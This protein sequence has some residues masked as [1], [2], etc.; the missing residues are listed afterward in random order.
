MFFRVRF[1]YVMSLLLIVGLCSIAQTRGGGPMETISIRVNEGTNL[2]LDLSPDGRNIA[3]DL[4]GQLWLVP[5]GGGN[6]R[7]I[8]DAVRD[9]AEDN[10][11]SFS[12]DGK[13]IVF[14]GERN[15]RTGLFLLDVATGNV[16]QLTQISD[17]ES[18]DGDAAWSPDGRSIAFARAVPPDIKAG[19]RWHFVVMVLDV[20]SGATRELPI[21]GIEKPQLRDPV[22]INGGKEIAFVALKTR[23]EHGG[24]VWAVAAAG[25]AA[26]ALT[27]GSV[28]VRSPA[29]SADGQRMAYFADDTDGRTQIYVL[30]TGGGTPIR[31]TNEAD[32]TPTHIRWIKNDGSLLYTANG[33]LWTVAPTGGAPSEI[34]FTAALSI[35]RPRVTL[36]PA[37]F[38][39]P[40]Q[41][42]PARGFMGLAISP[43]GKQIGM[44]ALGK[45]WIFP[46]GSSPKAVADVPFEA[47][48]L[49]WSPDGGEV[50]WTAGVSAKEDIFATDVKTGATRQVT[51]LPGREAFPV[52]SPDGRY[53]AFVHF[54]NADDSNL[55]FVDAKANN[56]A[57]VAQTRD[58]GSVSTTPACTPQWSPESD[59]LLVC[60]GTDPGQLGKATF[61]PLTGQRQP[62]AHFP[63]APIFLSW[64]PE[65]K[66]VW[67]RHDR[68]WQAGFDRTGM[69]GEPQ[70]V[71]SSAALYASASRDGA[72]LFVSDGGLKL[73][74]PSGVEQKLGWP[75]TF[76]RP[77]A[78]S[79]L[80][81]N[82]RIIDGTGAPATK[83]SDILIERGRVVRIAPTGA[84][85][86]G[87]A[88]VVDAAGR[89]VIPGLMDLHAHTYRPDLLP[90]YPYFGITTIRDQG[91]NIGPLVSYAS[92]IAAGVLPGPRVS[93]GGFQFY[94]DWNF[95][96]EQGRGI[97]PEADP[98][99]IER[100]VALLAAFGAQ[101]IKTRTFR[102]WD[103]NARMIKEAHRLGMRATGHC[104]HPLPLVAAGMNAKEHIGLC[105]ERGNSH[106]YDD[107][108]QLFK[109]ARISVIPT[110]AYFE[111]TLR[112]AAKD[113]FLDTDKELAPFVPA[114]DNFSNMVDMDADLL[115]MWK[116]EYASTLEGTTKLWRA[117]IN[118]GTGSDIWQ[119]PIGVHWELEQ[120]VGAGLT[121]LEAIHAAT[122]GSA[123]I[124]GADKEFGTI[125]VGKWADLV[126][127]DADPLSDIRNT[128]RIWQVFQSGAMI[129]R[130]A[131]LKVMKPR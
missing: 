56:I 70:A 82:V 34:K 119:I 2:G 80:I 42:E 46:V 114:R 14:R 39:E 67:V 108:V 58:L 109:A 85:P 37:R 95:D 113:D 18:Y 49:T 64:T 92:D 111:Q 99:H 31:L 121:P 23:A 8:T 54:P 41:K 89:V 5:A 3:I 43:D 118:L 130:N 88:R 126:I 65:K 71:G 101:H 44:L 25:G 72:M 103:I 75:V 94:S 112:I 24:R 17:P 30:A 33:R 96:E 90:G 97:E 15:G 131:I 74:S 32:V 35:T 11:P 26:H 4:L 36:P 48:G 52:Y 79:T 69:Q 81:R 117:G 59:G 115:K 12:P 66:I 76:D 21:T 57:D 104:S 129:D 61:V 38:P 106:I 6:A 125:E 93:Y 100:S 20:A 22:W 13:R 105:E 45:L 47:T 123:R 1:V 98:D 84:I 40:G 110:F 27:D 77:F 68:L 16:R 128:R 86:T 55:R 102:R 78:E 19:T 120:L 63:N 10:D 9:V 73:R 62:I 122:G 91:S 7:A 29:F 87:K 107:I 28:A 83:P 50:A 124:L 127:L 53:L 116:R 51:S 60:G